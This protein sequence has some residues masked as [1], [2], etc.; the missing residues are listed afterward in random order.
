MRRPRRQ[1][2]GHHGGHRLGLGLVL[3]LG[4]AG[5]VAAGCSGGGT[6]AAPE[7]P[8]APVDNPSAPPPAE[9]PPPLGVIVTVSADDLPG[10]FAE[11]NLYN[12]IPGFLRDLDDPLLRGLGLQARGAG[13][14]GGQGFVNQEDGILVFVVTI[15]TPT[16]DEAPTVVR[17][18][19]GLSVEAVHQLVSPSDALFEGAPRAAPRV[20]EAATASFLRYGL[21][22]DGERL[23]DVATDLVVFARAGSVVFVQASID[24]RA[25]PAGARVDVVALARVIDAR[26]QAEQAGRA[27]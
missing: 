2:G 15:V 5:I 10:G 13:M 18:L 27:S 22:E 14:A 11:I 4:I 9:D 19:A 16:P 26:L 1:H 6:A 20:G 23:R 8:I 21:E 12:D 7:I 25:N 3:G 17:H 24:A